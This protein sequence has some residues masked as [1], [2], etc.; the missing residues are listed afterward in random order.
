MRMSWLGR[1]DSNLPLAPESKSSPLAGLLN[2]IIPSLPF[3]GRKREGPKKVGR[4]LGSKR[5]INCSV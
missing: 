4:E 1:K 3:P 2:G 5:C